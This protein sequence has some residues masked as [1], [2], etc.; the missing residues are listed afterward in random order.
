MNTLK[1]ATVKPNSYNDIYQGK[2]MFCQSEIIFEYN[3]LTID[4]WNR[5]PPHY[6]RPRLP[7]S[8]AADKYVYFPLYYSDLVLLY[9]R[10][11]PR[12][13]DHIEDLDGLIA[14]N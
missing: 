7:L 12:Q 2:S 4:I 14:L 3:V 11:L 1:W 13:I 8:H 10:Y 9:F 5:N 6:A